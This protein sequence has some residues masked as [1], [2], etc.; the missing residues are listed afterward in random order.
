MRRRVNSLPAAEVSIQTE[1]LRLRKLNQGDAGALFSYRSLPDVYLYQSFHPAAISDA[2]AFI[3]GTADQLDQP[4]TWYQLGIFLGDDHILIGDIGIH[5]VN[6]ERGEVELGFTL[7]PEFQGKGYAT[8]AVPAVTSHLF[9]ALGKRRITVDVDPRNFRSR[10]LASRLGMVQAGY[11]AE[12]VRGGNTCEG[13]IYTLDADR[14]PYS[15]QT[16][17]PG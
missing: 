7:A 10:R 13:L 11:Y 8:E 6:A 17:G 4:G 2:A 3:S 12:S 15:S 14:W 9:S 5:F 1:R 16:A